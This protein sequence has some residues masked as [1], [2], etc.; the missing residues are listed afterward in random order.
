M[1]KNLTIAS[2]A[3]ANSFNGDSVWLV[4][5]EIHVRNHQT[6]AEVEQIRV[7]KND[8]AITIDGQVYEPM[9][10]DFDMKETQNQLPSVSVTIQD[11]GEIVGPAMQRYGGGVGFEVDLIM[12]RVPPGTTVVT[13][14][15]E[16]VEFF[17]VLT[18][19]YKDWVA[20]WSLGAENPLRKM[21]PLRR[22]EP[23][24]CSFRYK[25][26]DTCAYTGG[27]PTCDLS[28][29]GPNGCKAHSN[30]KNF[31]GYPGIIVRG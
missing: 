16:L 1:S 6:G 27:R 8:E 15:P 14:E 19:S 2:I 17:T 22:Q 31:G 29:D 24:Q 28:F 12:V 7:V 3:D 13:T 5:M 25:D 21:F 10:F 11:Q 26:P 30:S 20:S 23:D 4:A 18:A 9:S